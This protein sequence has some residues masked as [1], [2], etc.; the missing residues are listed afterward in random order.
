MQF[1]VYKKENDIMGIF[2]KFSLPLRSGM[3]KTG[4]NGCIPLQNPSQGEHL[5]KP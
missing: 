5:P 1:L 2:D 3:K 4:K